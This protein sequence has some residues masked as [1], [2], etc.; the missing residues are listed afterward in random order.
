MSNGKNNKVLL[1]SGILLALTSSFCC[2]V[3]LLAIVS[4]T[5]GVVSAFSW[6]APLR[7]YLLGTT[8]LILGVAFYQVYKPRQKDACGCEEKKSVLQSKTFLWII[9]AISVLLSAFPYY[10]TYFQPKAPQQQIVI[11]NSASVQQAV[12]HIQ[13][14]SC[15]A[16]E[17]HVNNTLQQKKG[18]QH[19]NTFYAKGI[20]I[21]KFD[22]AQIS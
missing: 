8:V 20:S 12:L 10:A 14:M 21:V 19:V 16:C 6:A 7:L 3:P 17:G 9:A 2:I 22:S 18:V 5:G 4:G 1:G 15:E 11:N 13:G